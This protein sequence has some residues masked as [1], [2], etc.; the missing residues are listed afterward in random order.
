M[1]VTL[2]EWLPGP[3]GGNT[4]RSAVSTLIAT[5]MMLLSINAWKV[6]WLKVRPVAFHCASSN[7][8]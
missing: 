2:M 3:K 5:T 1:I 7:A 6:S 4:K 8:A